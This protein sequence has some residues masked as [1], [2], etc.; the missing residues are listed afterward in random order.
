MKRK[1]LAMF[2]TAAM[3]AGVLAGCGNSEKNPGGG[4]TGRN[5]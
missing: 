1:V 2:L 3:A 5:K 4:Q